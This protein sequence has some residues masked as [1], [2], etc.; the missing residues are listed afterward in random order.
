MLDGIDA[1]DV[2]HE[3]NEQGLNGA[4]G[5]V[6]IF[7]VDWLLNIGTVPGW[8]IPCKN[9]KPPGWVDG[10]PAPPSVDSAVGILPDKM[11]CKENALALKSQKMISIEEKWKLSFN[12]TRNV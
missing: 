8:L 10:C 6:F 4:F 11:D 5:E 1:T 3:D 9:N 7:G 12:S 2:S